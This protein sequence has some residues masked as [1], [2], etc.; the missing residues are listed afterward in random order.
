MA[1]TTLR[2]FNLAYGSVVIESKI[3]V[4]IKFWYQKND[5]KYLKEK[6]F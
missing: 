4:L 5:W 3:V 6:S 1:F 2:P